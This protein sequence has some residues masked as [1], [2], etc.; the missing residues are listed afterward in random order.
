METRNMRR[1]VLPL[2]IASMALV[3]A[4]CGNGSG[5]A[6]GTSTGN[7]TTP[8][9]SRPDPTEFAGYVRTPPLNV[10]DVTIP[11][12]H[13]QLVNMKAEP[14]GVRLVYFGFGTCPDVCPATL[15]YVKM[16]LAELPEADQQRVSVDVITVDPSR[17]TPDKWEPYVHQF[18][19]TANALRTED[20]YLLRT[21]AKEFGADY[22]VKFDEDGKRQVAHTDDLYAIDD[23]GTI[24]LAWPYGTAPIDIETDLRR[25]LAGE[26]PDADA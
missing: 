21:S 25:L 12:V 5:S 18:V 24:I 15:G 3:A 14:G 9:T 4:A 6:T 10:A 1:V 17:D 16:A 13:D 19:A 8:T 22:Q 26:R 7:D 20:P 2:V 23:E 11:D